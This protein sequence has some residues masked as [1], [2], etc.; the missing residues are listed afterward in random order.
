MTTKTSSS[1]SRASLLIGFLAGGWAATL[2]IVFLPNLGLGV[3]TANA[4]DEPATQPAENPLPIPIPLPDFGNSN[5]GNPELPGRLQGRG[6][7]A[8]GGGTSDSNNRAIAISASIGGGESAVY[9]F[10]TASQRLLV[11]QY[12]GLVN[13]NRPLRPGDKGGLR[14]LAARHMDFDLRLEGYRDLSE[15]TRNELKQRWEKAYGASV[16]NKGGALPTKK[17]VGNK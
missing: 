1:L 7:S 8:P 15:R 16:K 4:E 14:L 9:Y 2:L 12:R 13:G 11:Y 6:F 10:D 5:G 3:R 17:V